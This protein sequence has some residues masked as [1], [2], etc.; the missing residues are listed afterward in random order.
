M[1]GTLSQ[2]IALVSYGNAYLS[3]KETAEGFS[4]SNSTFTFCN[5]VDFRTFTNSLFSKTPKEDV[6]AENP[7]EWFAYMKQS[8]CRKLA[9]Y[10]Q[11]S[12]GQSPAKD[13]QMAG[14]IGG[15]GTWYIE[16][17]YGKHSNYWTSRWEV[18]RQNAEDNR[19]WSVS[20]GMVSG[21]QA[22]NNLQIDREI[23]KEKLGETLDAIAAFAKE[24]DLGNWAAV[25]ERA[26]TALDSTNPSENYYHKDLFPPGQYGL[27]S[28]QLLFA[29]G[30]AW[31]FGGMGSWNDL[32]FGNDEDNE[33]YNSLSGQLYSLINMSIVAAVNSD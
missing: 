25:F 10:Y 2:L 17:V 3:N 16:A 24:Q 7:E 19:I 8:G 31:V 20:Y 29:A 22:T 27:L 23:T 33:R 18:T 26:R 30:S 32:G 6:V 12:Q 9:L 5:K 28:Q 1:T 13:H 21:K 4:E 14:F 11:S 15:G